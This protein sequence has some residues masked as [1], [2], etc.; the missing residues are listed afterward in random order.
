MNM[1]KI[2][3]QIEFNKRDNQEDHPVQD[4]CSPDYG[5]S[6]QSNTNFIANVPITINTTNNITCSNAFFPP[7]SSGFLIDIFSI[8]FL[9]IIC[10]NNF[11]DTIQGQHNYY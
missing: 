7:V 5:K 10:S 8:S 4:N 3:F 9:F 2:F 11:I 1:K 6:N